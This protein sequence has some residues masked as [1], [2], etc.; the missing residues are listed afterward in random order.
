MR[1][2]DFLKVAAATTLIEPTGVAKAFFHDEHSHAAHSTYASPR[3]AMQS[4]PEKIAFVT[5]TYFATGRKQPDFLAIVDVDPKSPTYSQVIHR[6]RDALR[7]RRAAPFRL[8]RLQQLS[9]RSRNIAAIPRHPRA[10]LDADPHRRRGR[11][12]AGRKCTR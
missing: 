7:R 5:A 2:R 11:S 12:R 8:E 9:R 4:E 6:V 10:A 3:E 1:R